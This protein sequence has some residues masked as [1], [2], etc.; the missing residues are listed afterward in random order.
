[1]KI[2]LVEDDAALAV[3]FRM[4]LGRRGKGTLEIAHAFTGEEALR[5]VSMI[6]PDVLLLDIMLPGMDGIEVC[7]SPMCAAGLG[8]H[9]SGHSHGP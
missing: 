8:R 9:Q 1:M 6:R 5:Q 4:F 2:L 7:L 3:L